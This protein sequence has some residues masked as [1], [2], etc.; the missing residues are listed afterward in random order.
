MTAWPI[1]KDWW[2][3]QWDAYPEPQ[4]QSTS[5]PVDEYTDLQCVCR[6]TDSVCTVSELLP[7]TQ[8]YFDVFVIDRQTD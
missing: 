8:Y 3:K 6:G 2:W 4:D 1:L 7:D 5:D